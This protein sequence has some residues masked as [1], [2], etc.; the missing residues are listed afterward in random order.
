MAELWITLA[1]VAVG[2]VF[3]LFLSLRSFGKARLIEDTPTS[4]ITSAA[5]GYVELI[6]SAVPDQQLLSAPLSGKACLWFRFRVERY[7]TTGKRSSWRVLRSGT[8]ERSFFLEDDTGRCHI[9]PEG[10]DVRLRQ[11]KRWYGN[12]EIPVPNSDRTGTNFFLSGQRYRYTESLIQDGD[13]L[14]ALGSFNTVAPES[15]DIQIQTKASE[16]IDDW[17]SHK[18]YLRSKGDMEGEVSDSEWTQFRLSAEKEAHAFV[19]ANYDSSVAHVLQ[20]PDSDR[21]HFILASKNPLKLARNYR[22]RGVFILVFFL[23]LVG[24]LY[25]LIGEI[26]I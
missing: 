25:H 6:G 10:A 23:L 7:D 18:S 12:S 13:L 19:M 16:I 5:Q 14:Y 9:H 21:Q 3:C 2:A 4:K 17:K 20:K 26:S 22:R 1:F 15:S 11:S 24:L 8:S